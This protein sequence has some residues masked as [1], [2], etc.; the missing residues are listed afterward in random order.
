MTF[1]IEFNKVLGN[2]RTQIKQNNKDIKILSIF[3]TRDETT[4][5]EENYKNVERQKGV[6]Q[7]IYLVSAK[8]IG[9][10]K[11]NFVVN[12]PSDLPIPFRI[13]ISIRTL[14]RK[15][16][17]LSYTH[18]FKVDGDIKLPLDYLSNLLDK[19]GCVA[20]IGSALLISVSFFIERMMGAYP[21]N[22]C[23]DGYVLAFGASTLGVFPPSYDGNGIIETL[24]NPISKNIEYFYGT[25]YYKFG[26]PLKILLMNKLLFM[27]KNPIEGLKSLIYCIS[28]YIS[29]IVNREKRYEWC[30]NYSKVA[31]S[32]YCWKIYFSSRKRIRPLKP[33]QR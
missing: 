10:H 25:E 14:L 26:L 21:L 33:Q 11:N 15:I 3:L 24:P 22:Y 4:F 29:A 13:G 9:N 16:D 30:K 31:N 12:V 20:G 32:P 5:L 19:G 7:N 18:I 2:K 28:G 17:L 6:H 23:D 8:P 1:L 27:L